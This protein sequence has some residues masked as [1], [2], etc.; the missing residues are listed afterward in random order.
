MED[1]I[2]ANWESENKKTS[3]ESTY[4]DRL[5]ETR[6]FPDGIRIPIVDPYELAGLKHETE[7][8]GGGQNAGTGQ[9]P[10]SNSDEEPTEEPVV[11][12]QGWRIWCAG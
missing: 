9:D 10:E 1:N 3:S 8:T 7:A 6:V 4:K 11:E 2:I 12:N 5:D